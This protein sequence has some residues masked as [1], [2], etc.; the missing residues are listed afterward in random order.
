[1][2]KDLDKCKFMRSIKLELLRARKV[3]FGKIGADHVSLERRKKY[4]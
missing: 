4:I 1:M 3:G 2:I